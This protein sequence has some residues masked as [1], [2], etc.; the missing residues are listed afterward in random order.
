[1]LSGIGT[2]VGVFEKSM[3]QKEKEKKRACVLSR[4][5]SY[6]LTHINN[7]FW[8]L[9]FFPTFSISNISPLINCIVF[10]SLDFLQVSL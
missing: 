3:C 8:S 10:V 6:F 5:T 1:M 4:V 9:H 7:L 2:E